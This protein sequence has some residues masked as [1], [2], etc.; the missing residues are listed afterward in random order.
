MGLRPGFR[1]LYGAELKDGCSPDCRRRF[2]QDDGFVGVL[3][4]N[5]PNKMALM[6]LRPG[7][8]RPYGAELKDGCSP[9]CRRRFAQD[10]GLVGG[11][12]HP[13]SYAENKKRSKKSQALRMTLLWKFEERHSKQISAY[14]TQSWL[15]K[16]KPDR[17]PQRQLKLRRK[18][19][20]ASKGL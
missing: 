2:A 13:V 20:W 3:K 16:S 9:E 5:N 8:R 18:R 11:E 6:G 10:D 15:P 1:R 4:K 17:N 19:S 7:F 12:K 14:G